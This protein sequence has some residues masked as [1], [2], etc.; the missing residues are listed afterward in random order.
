MDDKVYQGIVKTIANDL[1]ED[2]LNPYDH[3]LLMRNVVEY[4]I[5]TCEDIADETAVGESTY[6]WM[7]GNNIRKYFGV[8]E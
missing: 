4:I 5:S 7:V 1:T 2:K 8:E 3:A 6:G